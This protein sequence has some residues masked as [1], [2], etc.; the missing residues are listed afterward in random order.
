M[1]RPT[2]YTARLGREICARVKGGAT[3]R[4]AAQTLGIARSTIYSWRELGR[5]GREPYA[6][7]AAR[8]E[9]AQAGAEIHVMQQIVAAAASDWRA[10]AWWLERRFPKRWGLRQTVR[11][12]RALSSL[13]DEELEAEI[14]RQG[15]VRRDRIEQ[16]H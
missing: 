1:A 5:D 15:Y 2:L 13:T 8:L 7:F 3:V 16:P 4:V 6:D 12:E 10:G 14:A 9:R 11:L